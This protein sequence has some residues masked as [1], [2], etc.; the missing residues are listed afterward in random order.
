MTI[1]DYFALGILAV[2]GLWVT[3]MFVGRSSR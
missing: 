2:M 1:A 3:A